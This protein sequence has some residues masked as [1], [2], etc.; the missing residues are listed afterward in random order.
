[1]IP[2]VSFNSLGKRNIPIDSRRLRSPQRERRW[3]PLTSQASSRRPTCRHESSHQMYSFF[4]RRYL[5]M[6]AAECCSRTATQH[7][8][9]GS[10]APA[11][12]R[13]GLKEDNIPQV[14]GARRGGVGRP[15]GDTRVEQISASVSSSAARGIARRWATGP[16]TLLRALEA[17]YSEIWEE[18]SSPTYQ[19]ALPTGNK[20]F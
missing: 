3:L 20:R 8:S 14:V 18:S 10:A 7:S 19:W 13:G 5:P 16:V 17:S 12:S 4:P 6:P 1:L 9:R 15:A 2:Y 11:S